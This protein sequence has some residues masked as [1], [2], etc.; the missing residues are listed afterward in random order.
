MNCPILIIPF[1]IYPFIC[2]FPFTFVLSAF[3]VIVPSSILIPVFFTFN[4]ILSTVYLINDSDSFI[5]NSLTFCSFTIQG[6]VV[7]LFYAELSKYNCKYG[8]SFVTVN[9]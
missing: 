5:F 2:K 6:K 8:L 9:S 4:S 3:S 1:L 7:W